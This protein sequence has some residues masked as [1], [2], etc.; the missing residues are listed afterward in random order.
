MIEHLNVRVCES[1]LG[2]VFEVY[3][4]ACVFE[5]LEVRVHV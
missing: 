1:I 3:K 2:L 5:R 4:C